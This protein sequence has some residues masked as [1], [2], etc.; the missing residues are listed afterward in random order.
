[1]AIRIIV[2]LVLGY[3]IGTF[4]TSYI[5]GR[6][7]KLDIR[8]YGSGN[9]GT[10]NA[11]RVLGTKA[12]LITFAGDFFKAFIPLTI[13]KYVIWPDEPYLRL[14][15]LIMGFGIVI[16]HN[17]PAWLK[18]K[19]GKGIAATGGVF[20]AFDPWVFIPGIILFLG[21]IFLSKYVSLGSLCL[22]ILF[23]IWMI[24]TTKDDPYYVWIVAVTFLFTISAFIR[25]RAN[26]VRLAKGT[27][28]P[29]G[30]HVNPAAEPEE[31]VEKKEN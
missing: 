6:A 7:N 29:I 11:L 18:F 5:V 4:S 13:M 1:M 30:K 17:Y 19:G 22:S 21:V 8:K 26:I 9:A 28:N 25:H 27:E 15:M 23:P 2:C 12:G 31:S 16:G 24:L 10:T 14:M 20:V 3:L